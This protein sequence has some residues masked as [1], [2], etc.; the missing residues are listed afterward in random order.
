MSEP[1]T[2]QESLYKQYFR[3]NRLYKQITYYT[4]RFSEIHIYKLVLFLMVL[5]SVVKVKKIFF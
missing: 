5:T 3:L 1:K 2:W 4:W